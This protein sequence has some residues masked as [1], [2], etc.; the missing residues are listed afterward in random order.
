MDGDEGQ[1]AMP[2]KTDHNRH[3]GASSAAAST[4]EG[5]VWWLEYSLKLDLYTGVP[6]LYLRWDSGN[7]LTNNA[8]S[9]QK[10]L[11]KISYTN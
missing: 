10:L 2:P 5:V 6:C 8:E 3:L 11:G 4:I 9:S 1:R 7:H